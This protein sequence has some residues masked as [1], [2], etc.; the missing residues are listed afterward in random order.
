M[1]TQI[2]MMVWVAAAVCLIAVAAVRAVA[3]GCGPPNPYQCVGEGVSFTS[4]T[5]ALPVATSGCGQCPDG[6]RLFCDS[7]QTLVSSQY[8]DSV[9][10][11]SCCFDYDRDGC[12]HIANVT[13]ECVH[14]NWKGTNDPGNLGATASGDCQSDCGL[15][16]GMATTQWCMTKPGYYCPDGP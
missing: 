12:C 4:P 1:T 10:T 14:E 13:Y 2:R 9:G 7:G 11:G 15:P 8:T 16:G 6:I 5:C 3:N